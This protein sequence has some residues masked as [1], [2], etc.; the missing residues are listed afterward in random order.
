MATFEYHGPDYE[1]IRIKAEEGDEIPLEVAQTFA[2]LSIGRALD[3]IGS[4]IYNLAEEVRDFNSIKVE[5]E[6]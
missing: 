5:I 6:K 4:A 2:L 1:G 3:T